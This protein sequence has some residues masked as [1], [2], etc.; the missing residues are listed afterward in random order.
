VTTVPSWRTGDQSLQEV[1][2]LAPKRL[3]A[4]TAPGCALVRHAEAPHLVVCDDR[5]R[6]LVVDLQ[7]GAR[8]A[9]LRV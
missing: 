7:S 3:R 6:V 8:R 9:E 2:G 4:D 1:Q 5:G